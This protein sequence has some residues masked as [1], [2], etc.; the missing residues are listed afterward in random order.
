M[1]AKLYRSQEIFQTASMGAYDML[2]DLDASLVLGS[3]R[4]GGFQDWRVCVLAAGM[5]T[6]FAFCVCGQDLGEMGL[7]LPS[8]FYTSLHAATDTKYVGVCLG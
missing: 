1:R 5:V 8:T 6:G 2:F 4:H 3:E 7:Y